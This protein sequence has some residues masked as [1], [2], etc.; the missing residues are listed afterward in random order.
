MMW[1]LESQYIV[2]VQKGPER[3]R[4]DSRL[5]GDAQGVIAGLSILG[6]SDIFGQSRH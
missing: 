5:Q 4:R 1:V 2:H 6:R 3:V